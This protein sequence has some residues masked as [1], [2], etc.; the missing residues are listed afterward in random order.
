MSNISDFELNSLKEQLDYELK[1]VG[2]YKRYSKE[3]KDPQLK[4]KFEQIASN[5]QDHYIRLLN[6]L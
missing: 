3:C 4:I 6:Q 1:I 2:R 5:H